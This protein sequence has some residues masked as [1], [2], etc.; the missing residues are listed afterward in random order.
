MRS[1]AGR[2]DAGRRPPRRPD[3]GRPDTGEVVVIHDMFRR[4]FRLLPQLLAGVRDGDTARAQVL[5]THAA[6]LL[7]FL[8]HHH[9]H[10]E[11]LLLWPV[12]EPRVSVEPERVARMEDQHE[13]VAR[14]ISRLHELLPPWR[15][16]AGALDRDLLVAEVEAM[17]GPL[18]AH[19]EEEERV[20][21]PLVEEHLS[22]AEW[23]RLAEHGVDNLPKDKRLAMLSLGSLLEDIAPQERARFLTDLPLPAR[24]AWRVV[25]RRAYA[26]HVRTVR[27]GV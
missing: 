26:A 6:A 1:T 7:E 27:Q 4:E 3:P 11:D 19:L 8:H 16:R 22:V 5:A 14:S 24:V 17:T 13:V 12:L 21:L 15:E 2:S 9:H 25:G 10:G 23:K 18:L 20:V